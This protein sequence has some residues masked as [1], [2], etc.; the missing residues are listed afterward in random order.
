MY[1]MQ[2]PPSGAAAISAPSLLGQVLGITGAGFLIT[3]AA[4]YLFQGN[5][6]YGPSLIA[7]LVGFGFL[8]AISAT[9]A[10]PG[11]SLV[12]FYLF[13]LCEGIGIAPV[14]GYYVRGVGPEVV[15]NAAATTGMG[16]LALACV[17][18]MTS[19]DFRRLAGVAF[20]ALIG[21]VL[22]GVVS[23]FVHFIH[24]DTYSWLTLVVFTMLVL[25]DFARIRA[26]GGGA[27]P[28]QLATSIYL[29]AI[30]I[31]LALLQI[32]GGRRRSD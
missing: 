14:I 4:A 19:I 9:R 5:I 28:V 30:N 11:L 1:Q 20:F 13:T 29:D 15:V 6:G 23:L 18:Y 25:V 10:N 24:P 17:V 32:F 7:M 3:A 26:G 16:M 12:M 22:V 31:F 27:T 21:L 8:I 2:R